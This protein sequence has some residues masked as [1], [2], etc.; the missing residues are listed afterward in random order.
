MQITTLSALDD[1]ALTDALNAV[2]EQYVVPFR[3]TLEQTR[4]HIAANAI[5]REHSPLLLDETGRLV[6]LAAL[7]VR[8]DRGWVGGFGLTVHAR[9]QGLS[10][11]LM[12]VL[13]DAAR[14]LGL[15]QV[16]LE[17]LCNN[18]AAIHVY[19]KAG[20]VRTRELRFLVREAGVSKPPETD[21]AVSSAAAARIL[22]HAARLHP[23]APCW[24]REAASLAATPDL[25]G[26]VVGS[27]A[28]PT[29]FALARASNAELRI[30]DVAAADVAH[31][32]PLVAALASRFPDRRMVLGN[33]PADS[34]IGLALERQGWHEPL[35][36]YE[37]VYHCSPAD[38]AAPGEPRQANTSSA[39]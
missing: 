5:S 2:Y 38:D 23:V 7:G 29:A 26:F 24:Q 35:R 33:E 4:L 28:A 39:W 30:A 6:G 9:G 12:T 17:V 36:Q 21:G 32:P 22:P 11:V 34:P 27:A 13:L 20:F 1:Q 19:Q 18:A 15:R 14:R 37:M 16:Q 31:I 10:R 8:G 3:L 25:Q